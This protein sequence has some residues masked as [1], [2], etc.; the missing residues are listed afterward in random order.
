MSVSAKEF[1]KCMGKCLLSICMGVAIFLLFAIVYESACNKLERNANHDY[2]EVDI[3]DL[4]NIVIHGYN[5][6]QAKEEYLLDRWQTEDGVIA[7][8]IYFEEADNTK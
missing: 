5:G 8:T 3:S 2:V 7:V 4:R 6:Y 1:L